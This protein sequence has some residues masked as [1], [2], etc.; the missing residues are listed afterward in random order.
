MIFR[1]TLQGLGYS[2][3]AVISGVGEL[4]GRT[5]GGWLAVHKLGYFGICIANP[6]AWAFALCYCVVMVILKLRKEEAGAKL[7]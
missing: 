1:N 6:F 3:Q 4:L 7:N 5:L 2:T